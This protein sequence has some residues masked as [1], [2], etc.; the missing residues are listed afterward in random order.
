MQCLCDLADFATEVAGKLQV[1][2]RFPQTLQ[3]ETEVELMELMELL[4]LVE[5]VEL[6]GSPSCEKKPPL[7]LQSVD[8][9][10]SCHRL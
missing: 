3:A 7:Q 2:L 8:H 10:E 9:A 1:Q 6:Q 4:E 5:L